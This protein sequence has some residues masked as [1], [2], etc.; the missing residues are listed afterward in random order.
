VTDQDRQTFLEQFAADRP[1]CIGFVVLGG[2]FGESVD[3]SA[4]RLSG[5]ICVG[6]GLPP[7][8]VARS[9]LER[10]YRARGMDGRAVAFHQP[11]MV[12]VLQ[13]AGRLLRDPADR[14][15]LCLVD[16]RFR[17]AA[18]R[19][20]FPSHWDSRTLRAADVAADLASFWHP[21]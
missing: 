17:D 19:Q 15:T 7:P 3:F 12:K 6:V 21:A 1:P 9:N 2:V 20:F 11:A 13:M 10:Y 5:V 14:G 16:S 18:Y 8:S 4:A